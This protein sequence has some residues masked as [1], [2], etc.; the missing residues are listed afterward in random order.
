MKYFVVSN[1]AFLKIISSKN[2]FQLSRVLPYGINIKYMVFKS[3]Y[4]W[5]KFEKF[6]K[7][8]PREASATN[9]LEKWSQYGPEH[10]FLAYN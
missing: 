1:F 8:F 2:L 10:G 7:V 5:R 6:G 4:L 3:T 9:C